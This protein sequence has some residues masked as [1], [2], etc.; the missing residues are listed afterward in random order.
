MPASVRA[1]RRAA[2]R[3]GDFR[4]RCSRQVAGSQQDDIQAA[5]ISCQQAARIQQLL[6][7]L[8]ERCEREIRLQSKRHQ[9]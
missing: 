6:E 5:A 7:H 3:G 8:I 4:G 9:P 1:G 2:E